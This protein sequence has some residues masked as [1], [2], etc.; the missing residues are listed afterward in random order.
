[1]QRHGIGRQRQRSSSGSTPHD[2][3]TIPQICSS[4][5]LPLDQPRQGALRYPDI[6]SN[7]RTVH[8]VRFDPPLIH[9]SHH[10]P[11]TR[12]GGSTPITAV[13][14]STQIPIAPAAP[15]YV[16]LSA[17]SSLGGFRTPAAE[18]AA[19]SLKRPA[20]ETLHNRRHGAISWNGMR[21]P[22]E[23]ARNAQRRQAEYDRLPA[24]RINTGTSNPEQGYVC[25]GRPKVQ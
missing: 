23:A 10:R 16:P 25:T 18:Y 5:S 7:Q 22:T 4:R 11:P 13:A 12:W 8:D 17:V 6:F 14:R 3:A 1:V 20:S 19:P 9:Q 21:P 24:V 15:P 2:R